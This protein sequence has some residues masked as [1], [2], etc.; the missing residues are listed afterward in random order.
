MTTGRIN[1]VAILFIGGLF[2]LK[3][4]DE[5]SL[6]SRFFIVPV[7][8]EAHEKRKKVNNTHQQKIE[9]I[10]FWKIGFAILLCMCF[11]VLFRG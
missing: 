10:L 3:R 1:Q 7:R 9:A 2:C 5:S 6:G 11:Y 4:E 8:R